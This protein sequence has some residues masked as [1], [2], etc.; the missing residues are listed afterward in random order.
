MNCGIEGFQKVRSILRKLAHIVVLFLF[1]REKT[2]FFSGSSFVRYKN[3]DFLIDMD[4][5]YC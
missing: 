3:Q 2:E 5:D 4:A 1:F